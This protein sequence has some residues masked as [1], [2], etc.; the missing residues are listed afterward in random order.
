MNLLEVKNYDG[1]IYLKGDNLKDIL[2]SNPLHVIP[3]GDIVVFFS[4]NTSLTRVRSLLKHAV[5]TVDIMIEGG[6]E[7]GNGEEKSKNN[8]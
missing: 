7:N 4:N 6:G 2:S 1:Q 8:L 3:I 5:K